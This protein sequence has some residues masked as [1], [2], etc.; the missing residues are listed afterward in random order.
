VPNPEVQGLNLREFRSELSLGNRI[1][2]ALW[3]IVWVL[4]FRPSPRPFHAWRRMLLGLFGARLGSGVRVYNSARIWAPWHLSMGD[5]S[6]L[7]DFVDCYAV[8]RIDIGAHTVVSQYTHL[9]TAT[10]DVDQPGFPL[11]T[12]PI[13][14]GSQAWVAADAFVGP[15]VTVGDGAVVGARASVFKDVEPWTVVGGTPARMIRR[16]EHPSSA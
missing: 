10:H 15:G 1:A 11:V 5:F 7:G 14:I 8:D 4:L 2:R 16:R 9:C 3:G 13:R 6:V 12:A